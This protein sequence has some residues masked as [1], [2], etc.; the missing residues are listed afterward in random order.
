[1]VITNCGRIEEKWEAQNLCGFF[2]KLNAATKKIFFHY[3]S[4][5]YS[6]LIDVKVTNNV[7]GPSC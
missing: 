1:M 5:N 2:K 3:H 6:L 4:Q 7:G